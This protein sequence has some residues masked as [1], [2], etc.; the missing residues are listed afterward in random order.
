MTLETPF[1]LLDHLFSEKCCRLSGPYLI[2]Q[3][4]INTKLQTSLLESQ[5]LMSLYLQL[6]Y[7][8]TLWKG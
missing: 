1:R 5:K 7:Y 6:W 3:Q 8:S 4:F 2:Y